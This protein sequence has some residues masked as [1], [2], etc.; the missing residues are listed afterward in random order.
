MKGD[1]EKAEEK[2]IATTNEKFIVSVIISQQNER[3][4]SVFNVCSIVQI[5]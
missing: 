3:D 5:T 4:E 1:E 2:K